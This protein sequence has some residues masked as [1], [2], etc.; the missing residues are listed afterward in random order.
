MPATQPP[1]DN[2]PFQTLERIAVALIVPE[3]E[4]F[5]R[6]STLDQWIERMREKY[7]PDFES[8]VGG[9]D[10]ADPVEAKAA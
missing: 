10:D 2:P 6:T 1:S 4:E 3:S 9:A 7:G 8:D 5:I